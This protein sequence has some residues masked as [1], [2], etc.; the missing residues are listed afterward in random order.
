MKFFIAISLF[1]TALFSTQAQAQSAPSSKSDEE[2]SS[3]HWSYA[4]LAQL[5]ECAELDGCLGT[6]SYFD[7]ARPD[8][9]LSR[10]EAALT[11]VKIF[12]RSESY[13][14]IQ[15]AH[16]DSFIHDSRSPYFLRT[17]E[18]RDEMKALLN[19][20]EEEIK[21]LGLVDVVTLERTLIAASLKN[22]HLTD[23]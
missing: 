21:Q 9:H 16:V 11:T 19:E 6:L 10:R 2:I 17:L 13:N 4:T 3:A 8:F 18:A 14:Q 5:M 23:V 12:Y 1:V 7:F 15:D 20:Y 22:A